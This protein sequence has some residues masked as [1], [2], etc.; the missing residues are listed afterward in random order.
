M[1]SIVP[2]IHI[3][4]CL[5]LLIFIWVAEARPIACLGIGDR[6]DL[7]TPI[8][9]LEFLSKRDDT[10]SYLR[11]QLINPKGVIAVLLL[12]GG[13]V[14]QKAIAQGTGGEHD[15]FTPVVFSFGW[16]SY[17]FNSVAGAIGEGTFLPEP[18]CPVTV[19][20]IDSGHTRQN[21]SWILGR[22]LRDLELKV[23]EETA[24]NGRLS[25]LL[26]TVYKAKHFEGEDR[27]IFR[28]KRR[29][30]WYGFAIGVVAQLIVAAAPIYAPWRDNSQPRR[31]WSILL[32]TVAGNLLASCSSFIPA[33]RKEKYKGDGS[34]QTYAI[35]RG[36]GHRHVFIFLPNTL[37]R[38]IPPRLPNL[39]HLA[40]T[41]DPASFAVRLLSIFPA[42]LWV[43]LLL[44]VGGIDQHTWFLL[45]VG[46]LG[47]V[48]NILLSGWRLEPET[49]GIALERLRRVA[50]E[51]EAPPEVRMGLVAPV[52]VAVAPMAPAA[53]IEREDDPS[54]LGRPNDI[55]RQPKVMKVLMDVERSFPGAGHALLP[56]FFPGGFHEDWRGDSISKR[57]IRTRLQETRPNWYTRGDL[58]ED[59]PNRQ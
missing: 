44:I 38:D 9:P 11:T 1:L 36:N 3:S 26:V 25:G 34:R 56:I 21:Q 28:P 19:I 37:R 24:G 4:I 31:D 12:I 49:H 59:H 53:L 18:D 47:M 14:V 55:D 35:T 43:V 27:E 2:S 52:A 57:T 6:A 20:N 22:L 41:R 39:D 8:P 13:D 16:V 29:W 45:G 30:L 46:V 23:D 33:I 10:S 32:I 54:A 17:A 42:I 5:S 7:T 48:H 51:P 50:P 58:P 40:T 15:I